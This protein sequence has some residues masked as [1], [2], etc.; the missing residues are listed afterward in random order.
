MTNNSGG[1]EGG[2]EAGGGKDNQMTADLSDRYGVAAIDRNN[3]V[4][5]MKIAAANGDKQFIEELK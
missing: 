3:T 2:K 1:K 5:E 4:E